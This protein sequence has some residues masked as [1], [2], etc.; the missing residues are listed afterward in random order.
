MVHADEQLASCLLRYFKPVPRCTIDEVS[1]TC[2]LQLPNSCP[3]Q[4]ISVR[5]NRKILKNYACLEACKKLHE[6]GALT[7]SL[8][9][10]I[11]M[12]ERLMKETGMCCL[13]LQLYTSA[14]EHVPSIIWV[15]F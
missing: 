13:A 10:D 14:Y 7:D 1:N 12:E 5:G 8:V 9:P 6:L 11:V 3:V 2:T 4:L 15:F